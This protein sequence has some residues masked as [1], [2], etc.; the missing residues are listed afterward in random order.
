MRPEYE[1]FQ[2]EGYATTMVYDGKTA[3]VSTLDYAGLALRDQLNSCKRM[4]CVSKPNNYSVD[5]LYN[6]LSLTGGDKHISDVKQIPLLKEPTVDCEC[7]ELFNEIRRI[8]ETRNITACLHYIKTRTNLNPFSDSTNQMEKSLESISITIEDNENRDDSKY[9]VNVLIKA[10]DFKITQVESM[11][12][13]IILRRSITKPFDAGEYPLI[14][15]PGIGGI[16]IHEIIG[17]QFELSKSY[18]T[19]SPTKYKKGHLLFTENLTVV[20]AP[21]SLNPIKNFDDEGV[22]KTATMLIR[23]GA[24]LVPITDRYSV[25]V[26][27]DYDLTGNG[28]RESYLHYPESRMYNT[29][30][31]NGSDDANDVINSFSHGFYIEQ[32][33]YAFCNHRAG[34]V[35]ICVSKAKVIQC[36]KITDIPAIF[37]IEDKISS[38]FDI[39]YIC[40]D[41]V[42]LP[43]CCN[44]S[45][46]RLYVEYGSPTI[47]FNSVNIR[48]GFAYETH[49]S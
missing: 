1:T 14:F 34:T 19:Y 15:A 25:D 22:I 18:S 12:D 13:W 36:G 7:N 30:V 28:R 48:S 29:Y 38:F 3:N 26:H 17:H 42:L 16:L 10:N 32:I 40:D 46:G 5:Q 47:S 41:I 45:S 9:L 44:S 35:H 37:F 31:E 11:R 20:D 39:E 2:Q 27:S 33:S 24:I 49:V 43:G 6:H 4:I 8:V 21:L 23:N